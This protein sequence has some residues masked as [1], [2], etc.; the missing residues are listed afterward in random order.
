MVCLC[1]ARHECDGT[2]DLSGRRLFL[3]PLAGR[4]YAGRHRRGLLGR[5]T[6]SIRRWLSVHMTCMVVSYYMLV[7]G[8]IN[9]VQQLS[10]SLVYQAVVGK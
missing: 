6:R 4:G 3:S 8:A 1:H 10:R 9:E 5:V 2:R 7:G